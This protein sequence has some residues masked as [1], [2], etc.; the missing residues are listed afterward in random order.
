MTRKAA[1]MVSH[2]AKQGLLVGSA[3]ET[4]LRFLPPLIITPAD[5]DKAM[6]KLR[7]AIADELKVSLRKLPCQLR[8]NTY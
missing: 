1:P 5:I 4:V 7:A 6:N 8:P 2:C 3:H